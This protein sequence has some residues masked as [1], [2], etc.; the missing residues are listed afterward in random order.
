MLRYLL[1]RR[2]T[3]MLA[4]LACL[5]LA[6][7][8][9]APAYAVQV[10]EQPKIGGDDGGGA[11]RG[12]PDLPTGPSRTLRTGSQSA[13]TLHYRTVG[14]GSVEVASWVWRLRIV[15]RSLQAYSLHF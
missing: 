11:P 15:L 7:Q 10:Y 14:D 12:D 4:L 8:F 1:N 2:M 6:P 5:I 3:F 9:S 13:S